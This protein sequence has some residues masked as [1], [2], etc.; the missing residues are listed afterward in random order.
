MDDAVHKAIEDQIGHEFHAAYL[1]LAMAG[2]F[3]VQG[4]EG[5]GRWMRMQAQEEV[6]HAMR[7]FDFLVRRGTSV[8]LKD[9]PGPASE[10]GTPLDIFRQA[11][12]HEKEVTALINALLDLAVT[13][14]DYPTQLELQWFVTEQ[15]EE[16]ASVG[17]VVE[18]LEMVGE[19]RAALL[20]LDQRLGER[21][22]T[23]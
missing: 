13:K 23:D 17:Q 20:M 19:S 5:F 10:F 21:S 3:E 11:L 8:T 9:V 1:Y 16:E 6:G 15:V 18:Q 12:E 4:L 14:K 2:H 7:L 22:S